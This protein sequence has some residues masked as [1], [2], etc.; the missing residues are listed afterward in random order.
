MAKEI[1]LP[2]TDDQG[3]SP[4]QKELLVSKGKWVE[5]MTFQEAS[6]AIEKLPKSDYPHPGVWLMKISAMKMATKR[7]SD[8]PVLDKNGNPALDITFKVRHSKDDVREITGL[9]FFRKTASAVCKSEF[10]LAGLKI[11]LGFGSNDTPALSKLLD[12]PVWGSIKK[13]LLTDANDKVITNPDGSQKYFTELLGEF[14]KYD[15]AA[16]PRKGKPEMEGDPSEGGDIGGKFIGRKVSTSAPKTTS[17]VEDS[18]DFESDDKAQV[19][20]EVKEE[21][22]ITPA[23]DDWDE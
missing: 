18:N 13:I 11:A 19:K 2:V 7:G 12:I 10:R 17:L 16:E 9:F 5:G 4:K 8:E 14:R 22:V 20:T 3:A 6:E 21:E 23:K 15:K 1:S